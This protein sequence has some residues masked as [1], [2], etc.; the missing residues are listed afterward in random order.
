MKG[1]DISNTT[2]LYAVLLIS[3]KPKHGYELIKEIGGKLGK[4][5]SAGQIYPF[6]SKMKK[7]G[8]IAE[9]KSG[10]RQKKTYHLTAKG[11]A[12]SKK[13]IS[14]FSEMVAI[15]IESKICICGHCGCE[16]YR[17]GHTEK[18]NGKNL[19]FCCPHCATA[20]KKIGVTGT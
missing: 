20:F 12:F 4:R 6:L 15:A 1:I 17:G 13:M 16:I 3:E 9:K 8:L 5:I 7:Q 10:A 11:R 2:K 18:I 14:R 19:V